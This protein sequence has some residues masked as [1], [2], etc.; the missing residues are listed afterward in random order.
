MGFSNQFI[1]GIVIQEAIL[2][3][4]SSFIPSTLVS[5]MY[6]F[7]TSAQASYPNDPPKIGLVGALTVGFVLPQQQ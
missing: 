6:A 3:G 1:L 4:V 7:L 2:L 5:G